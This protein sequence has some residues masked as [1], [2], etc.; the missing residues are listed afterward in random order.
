MSQFAAQ[1]VTFHTRTLSVGGLFL[2]N[3]GSIGVGRPAP[4][5]LTADV[6]I[7]LKLIFDALHKLLAAIIFTMMV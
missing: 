7:F 1:R 2:A 3:G 5:S 4:P 6:D